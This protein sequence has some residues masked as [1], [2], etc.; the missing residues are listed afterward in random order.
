MTVVVTGMGLVSPLGRGVPANWRAL[1]AGE[2]AIGD[3]RRFEA[4]DFASAR[5]GEIAEFALPTALAPAA[6]CDLGTQFALVAC[7]EALEDAGL[8]GDRGNHVEL[9]A[10]TALVLATNFGGAIR[11]EGILEGV[12]GVSAASAGDFSESLFMGAADHVARV[13]ALGGPRTVL[14]L[15]CSSG[16]AAIGA[17]LDLIRCSRATIALAGGYDTL[18]RFSWSGLCA[19]RTL[20]ADCVRPFDLNRSGTQFTEGAGVLVLEELGHALA[21]GARVYAEVAG[22]ATNNN[23]FHMTAPAREG[24]GSARVMRLALEN[25]GLPPAAIDHINA[26]G[27]GTK[28]NDSTETQAVKAVF[29]EHARRLP[30]T[31]IKSSVGH[32]MGAAGSIE[33]VASILSIRDGLIPPTTHYETPDP[34]CD[35]DVVANQ[36]RAARVTCVLSNSAGIGGC[37][38]AAVFRKHE[39]GPGQ[40]QPASPL[41]SG[42]H[43]SQAGSRSRPRRVVITGCGPVSAIGIGRGAFWQA[44]AAG[45]DGFGESALLAAASGRS[46]L[47]AELVGFEAAPYLPS[48]KGYLDRASEIAFAGVA[49]ALRDAGLDLAAEDRGRVGLS[50]GTALGS[51]GT[52]ATYFADLLHKGPRLV[53]PILFPH[54]YSNTAVSLLAIDYRIEGLH[55]NFAAGMVAG[56][57]AIL[58]GFDAVRRGQADV[59]LAGGV[60]ALGP[61]AARGFDLLGCLS[62]GPN[63]GEERSAP[64]DAS[65]NGF[66]LGEGAGIVV[67]E[68]LEHAAARGARVLGELLG[69]GGAGDGGDG[70]APGCGLRNST[71]GAV[72]MALGE[73]GLAS[74]AVA[75]V[76]AHANGSVEGDRQE[77][78]GLAGALGAA[79]RAIP[80]TSTK[81]MTGETLGAGPALQ[82][83][84]ALQALADGALPPTLNTAAADPRL[85]ALDL[86]TATRTLARHGVI[87]VS[88]RDPGGAAA[89]LALGQA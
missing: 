21:R 50:L 16:T 44:V 43:P 1:C 22:A 4:K 41:E 67:I 27:T 56:A 59:V 35:L 39:A 87:L 70:A 29:G 65:R 13:F 58:A 79:G 6:G 5:A 37:N 71:A 78:V 76:F 10:R 52:A 8:G 72:A 9:R 30:V 42:R 53:K 19:L 46:R 49:L 23:A 45:V 48:P 81:P 75:A 80:V 12:A 86:A 15:S 54:T 66:L 7:A 83:I 63:G 85:P 25:A 26:H 82:L 60:D 31:S 11:G 2:S 55:L 40:R 38:A 73:A 33:A 14:S 47:A 68:S 3:I 64:F 74:E 28:P 20:A 17:A 69:G 88:A 32:M 77:A 62:P 51:L 61:A 84:A 34:E 24:A 57:Q 36:A 18:S 89:C